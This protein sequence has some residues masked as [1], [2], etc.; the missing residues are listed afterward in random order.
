[1]LTIDGVSMYSPKVPEFATE[2]ALFA[3]APGDPA[4]ERYR[5][6]KPGYRPDWWFSLRRSNNEPLLRLN[7]ESD[8][9]RTVEKKTVQLLKE[10]RGL[11]KTLGGASTEVIDW[12]ILKGLK[13]K[14]KS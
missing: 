11:C 10:V 6:V 4:G 2:A 7:V 13:K 1:M 8:S 3:P 5:L 12:G 9:R 14:V